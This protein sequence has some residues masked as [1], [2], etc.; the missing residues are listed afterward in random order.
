MREI[1]H[2]TT[3]EALEAARAAGA[4][5]GDTLETQGFIHASERSQVAEVANR[6]FRGR[7]DLIL[8]H[9]DEAR[10]SPPVVRENLEGGTIQYPHIYGP[11]NLD[12]VVR[13]TPYRSSDDGT[14]AD[15]PALP[16]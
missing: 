12:A 1:L 9:I 13:V 10:V 11:L 3:N 14:F 2:I 4:Y 6:L 8:L 7:T 16:E 15:P 5:R